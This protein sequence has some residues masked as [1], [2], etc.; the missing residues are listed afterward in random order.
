MLAECLH[1]FMNGFLVA[2]DLDEEIA[3]ACNDF[4][5]HDVLGMQSIRGNQRVAQILLAFN[6][7]LCRFHF[8]LIALSFFLTGS[9]HGAGSA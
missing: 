7:A 8:A 2:F 1:G 9:Y 3:T 6:Q 4:A 5:G